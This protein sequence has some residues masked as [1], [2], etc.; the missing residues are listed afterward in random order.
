MEHAAREAKKEFAAGYGVDEEDIGVIYI[1][2]CPSKMLLISQ[3]NESFYSDFDGAVSI[4]DIYNQLYTE[5][6]NLKKAKHSETE[7]YEINGFGLNFALPGGLSSLLNDNNNITITGI[8]NVIYILD[9]IQKGKLNNIELVE[10]HACPEGCNGGTLAVENM[11]MASNKMK[12]IVNEYGESRLPVGKKS[13]KTGDV[14]SELMYFDSGESTDDT[15]EIKITK[16][17]ER[18]KIYS[19][20]PGINC[21]ACGSPSCSTFADD[22]AAGSVKVN[23]CP[24]IFIEDLKH[25]LKDKILDNLELQK[26]LGE[27]YN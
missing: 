15:L 7:H 12:H 6:N 13:S 8:S 17:N 3:K 22:A 19:S 11:Y 5:I 10:L 23:D 25:K 21:G 14:F 16:I 24:F 2:A 1:T 9:E 4:S 18:N 26:K 27:R 20:L